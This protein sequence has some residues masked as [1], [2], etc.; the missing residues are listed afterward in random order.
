MKYNIFFTDNS[1]LSA[2]GTIDYTA[3]DIFIVRENNKIKYIMPTRN[4]KYIRSTDDTNDTD[5]TDVS[6][7]KER[8]SHYFGV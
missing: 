8:I 6:P 7:K 5:D 1:Q 2:T 3:N 4:V